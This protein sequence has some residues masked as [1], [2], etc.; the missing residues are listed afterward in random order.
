[1]GMAGSE[2]AEGALSRAIDW[3]VAKIADGA[4]RRKVEKLLDE[5]IMRAA[6]IFSTVDLASKFKDAHRVEEL[7]AHHT[8]EDKSKD[9]AIALFLGEDADEEA[10]A[11]VGDF[12]D[13]VTSIMAT[14][15]ESLADR[16]TLEAIEKLLSSSEDAFHSIEVLYAAFDRAS[17]DENASIVLLESAVK[18]VESGILEVDNILELADRMLDS[19]ASRYLRAYSFLCSGRPVDFT[20]LQ[21]IDGHDRLA[22]SL[23]AVAV[24]AGRAEDALQALDFCSFDTSDFASALQSVLEYPKKLNGQI[25]IVAPEDNGVIGFVE[26]LNFEHV[27]GCGAMMAAAG[28]SFGECAILNPLVREKELLARVSMAAAIASLDLI[29]LAQEAVESYRPWFAEPLLSQFKQVISMALY[30]LDKDQAMDLIG[31]LPK[32]LVIFAQDEQKKIALRE[33]LRSD[34]ALSTL[35][36]A[37]ARRNSELLFD[38]AVTL[39]RLDESWRAEVVSVFDRCREWAFPTLGMLVSY[40]CLINPDVDYEDYCKYGRHKEDG[41][42]YHLVAYKLFRES[43]P[44][45][46]IS[47]IEKG[48]EIMKSEPK[49]PDL[50]S[51][52]IWVP[53]LVENGREA[54]VE[55]LVGGVLPYAPYPHVAEFF[56]AIASCASSDALLGSIVDSLLDADF[57]DPKAAELIVRYLSSKGETDLAGRMAYAAFKK[58]PSE[59]LA[60]TAAYWL[61]DS[62][63]GVDDDIVEY[64]EEVDSPQMNLLL[65]GV[66]HDEGAREKQ[67]LYLERA[68]F[69]EGDA[70]TEALRLYAVWNVGDDDGEPRSILEVGQNTYIKLRSD[71]AGEC[72]W[73]FLANVDAVKAEGASG[74]AGFAFSTRSKEFIACR[75]LRV[76]DSV[77]LDGG[78]H[79]VIEI[80]P[81]G[82]LLARK[83][84]E[85]ISEAPGSIVFTGTPEEALQQLDTL[86][87]ENA[88]R[89]EIYKNG[90][91]TEE[92]VLYFG[93]ETGAQLTS[94]H[95]LEF[96]M[97]TICSASLPYRKCPLSRNVALGPD[98]MFLLSYNALIVLAMLDLP[99]KIVDAIRE[100]CF[101]TESTASRLIKEARAWCEEPFVGAGRLCHDGE[102]PVLYEYDSESR[103]YTKG[104]CLPLIA[105]VREIPTAKPS[106]ER[107]DKSIARLL[108]DNEVIDIQTARRNGFVF[109]TE[110]I[111]QAQMVDA[112]ELVS[113]CSVSL[114]LITLGFEEYVFNQYA[115]QMEEWGA[116]PVLEVD[117]VEAIQRAIIGA[118]LTMGNDVAVDSSRDGDDCASAD[119]SGQDE[120]KV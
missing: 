91:S 74:P 19:P 17:A 115:N 2:L 30:R 4:K 70:A 110:D 86:M 40:V 29:T 65:A 54:E 24:S 67:N 62:S 20:A 104:K 73:A 23:A 58:G 13:G 25:R 108:R 109:V 100:R 49:T 64:A 55:E 79:T 56:G 99:K 52:R 71:I 3:A 95:Q 112:F 72:T 81:V 88:P 57:E 47:H 102:R 69:S 61:I 111:L 87:R 114:M 75:G 33:C 101:L 90:Y 14:A 103:E 60:M 116:E 63:L 113:R 43:Y 6:L 36:W 92:G 120:P 96:T 41:A 50:L 80:G 46:A 34:V 39:I 42:T 78:A 31:L 97:Q 76:G 35:S 21:A 89:G 45:K 83:G 16:K 10:L 1:M 59:T 11:F 38:A 26:L 93:I 107:L 7:L 119:L 85:T 37:E 12:Y 68:A 5:T 9:D 84:F 18:Q 94:M 53:Y 27:Y 106:L 44:E 66:A 22:L 8:L 105:Q 82:S 77:L 98:C 51:S 48:I 117:I 32:E 118:S 28:F 15:D